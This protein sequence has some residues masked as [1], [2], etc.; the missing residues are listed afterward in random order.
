MELKP[1]LKTV[2]SINPVGFRYKEPAKSKLIAPS[3]QKV[4]QT[5]D[6]PYSICPRITIRTIS[7]FAHAQ[8]NIHPGFQKYCNY[9]TKTTYFYPEYLEKKMYDFSETIFTCFIV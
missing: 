9:E 5:D 1:E 8:L 4:I 7:S 3:L 2:L 6:F